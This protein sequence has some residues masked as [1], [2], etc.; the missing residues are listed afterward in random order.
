MGKV[1]NN[2]VTK[3]FAGKF[4]EDILFRQM[5]NKTIFSKRTPVT[6]PA[7]ADQSAVRN[8]FTEAAFHASAAMDNP[9]ASIDY[10]LM[11]TVQGLKSA[12]VAAITDFL[13]LPEIGGVFAAGYSGQVGDV[14]NIKPK[15]GYKITGID[16]TLL[17][18]TG[19]VIESGKAT[20]RQLNWQYTATKINASAA[21]TRLVLVARDR[22]GK[23]STF[24]KV[25]Q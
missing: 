4:G 7:S 24:E 1:K 22:L 2:Q 6:G 25:L 18:S 5:D 21:G 11:A 3:G 9:Q 8:N 14:I 15:V 13:T 19:A 23:E 10:K 16:V 20:P 12:Y 17:D